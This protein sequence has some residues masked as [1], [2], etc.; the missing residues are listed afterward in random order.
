VSL[1]VLWV[2]NMTSHHL[3]EYHSKRKDIDAAVEI[4][5]QQDFRSL[6]G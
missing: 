2:N 5:A 1:K 3:C 6:G 4:F